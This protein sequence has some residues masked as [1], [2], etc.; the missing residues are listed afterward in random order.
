MGVCHVQCQPA[1]RAPCALEAFQ[2][3]QQSNSGAPV[4]AGAMHPLWCAPV[5][6]TLRVLYS[7]VRANAM[8]PLSVCP[9]QLSQLLPDALFLHQ[10]DNLRLSSHGQRCSPCRLLLITRIAATRSQTIGELYAP[11]RYTVGAAR[12]ANDPTRIVRRAP[13]WACHLS[14]RLPLSDEQGKSDLR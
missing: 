11:S 13:S 2:A 6:C 8:T 1:G 10:H 7:C 14:L 3:W 9:M 12:L 5:H 4:C